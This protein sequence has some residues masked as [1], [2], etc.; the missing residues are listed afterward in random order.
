MVVEPAANMPEEVTAQPLDPFAFWPP[1]VSRI[2]GLGGHEAGGDEAYAF[3]TS[4]IHCDEGPAVFTLRFKGLKATRGSLTLSVNVLPLRANSIAFKAASDSIPFR[5]LILDEGVATIR[6]AATSGNSYAVL[7]YIYDET[8]ASAE[9]LEIDVRRV[10]D[11]D[12][13]TR[14]LIDAR[15]TL[16]STTTVHPVPR[17]VSREAPTLADPV[18]QMCTAAQFEEPVYREWVDRM[19][20]GKHR[21]RKHWEYVYVLQ[22]LRRYG[23]LAEGARGLGFGVGNETLPAVMAAMGC[24]V[25]ATDLPADHAQVADWSATNQH[26][27]SVEGLR[28]PTICPD[29]LFDQRVSFRAVDMS[30]LPEDMVDFDFIWSSCAFEHLGSI[31]A[32]LRFVEEAMRCLKPGG[33]AVHTTEFNLSS[34]DE[35]VD[36]GATVLF[37]RKDFERL[38]LSLISRGHEVAQF[39]YEQGDTEI[40]RHIDLPPFGGHSHLKIALGEFVATSF[41]IIVRRGLAT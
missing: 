22:S 2:G 31:P 21:H 32:G 20:I 16:F 25:V 6:V 35:T 19:E 24:T 12:A 30:A 4:Y 39:K 17:L 29:E 37:R 1:L 9:S 23:V 7:G 18:C 40:D 5:N 26:I 38:A 14:K 11:V 15:R 3:H 36:A 8:D 10:V 33:V 27:A 28:Q 34:N 41:G 13:F